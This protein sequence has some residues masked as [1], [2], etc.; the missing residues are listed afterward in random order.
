VSEPHTIRIG[1][2]SLLRQVYR[3]VEDDVLRQRLGEFLI[4]DADS[5]AQTITID[6]DAA[7]I[8][9]IQAPGHVCFDCLRRTVDARRHYWDP[10][11]GGPG[12]Y[13]L[14]RECEA[15]YDLD[16]LDGPVPDDVAHIPT[17]RRA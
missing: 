6:L 16:C 8:P 11:H 10:R 9:D 3:Q 13:H 15:Q 14:C 12:A 5:L 17:Q 7:S 4:L 1:L 2:V